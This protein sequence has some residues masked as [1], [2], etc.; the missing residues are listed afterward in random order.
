MIKENKGKLLLSSILILL[1]ILVGNYV[2]TVFIL[3]VHWLC[4]FFTFS[5]SK[6]KQQNN[7]VWNMIFWICPCISLFANGMSYVLLSD[8]TIEME[9][10]A[11]IFFGILFVL[12]EIILGR[13]IPR[14]KEGLVHMVGMILLMLL[15]VFVFYNDIMRL[16]R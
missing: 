12:I 8:T 7:K 10:I 11:P 1:P 5:D 3:L 14:D 2:M 13:P 9:S 4:L 15:M 6:N 16:I